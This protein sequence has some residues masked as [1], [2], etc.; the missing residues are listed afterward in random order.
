M[1]KNDFVIFVSLTLTFDLE[2]DQ[3]TAGIETNKEYFALS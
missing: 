2:I 1:A 3:N